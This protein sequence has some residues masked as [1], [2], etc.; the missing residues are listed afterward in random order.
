MGDEIDQAESI[1]RFLRSSSHIRRA[2]GRPHYS[3]YLP[4]VP[5]GEI[6]VYRTTGMEP[7]DITALGDQYVRKADHLLK[8]HC[9]LAAEQF[10]NE[11]L[12]VEAA[13]HPHV[14]HANVRGWTTDPKNR[15]AARKLADKA[16]L[17]VY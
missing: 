9:D 3:A 17:T 14:R 12:S 10:F 5:D 4:R 13:P 6:S 1:T 15:I 7:R 2:L 16:V 8:G 11:G